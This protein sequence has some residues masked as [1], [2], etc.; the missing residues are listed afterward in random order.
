[1]EG[2]SV[3]K[4]ANKLQLSSYMEEMDLKKRRILDRKSVV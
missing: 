1:M 3:E 4:I 2:V